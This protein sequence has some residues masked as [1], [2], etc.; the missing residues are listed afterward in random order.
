M[1]EAPHNS[2]DFTPL[3][4][5][6]TSELRDLSLGMQ[7]DPD[8]VPVS[9]QISL[10]EE[11]YHR[12]L[13]ESYQRGLADG[14]NLAERGLINVFRAL[15]TAAETVQALRE[16]ALRESEDELLH[17]IVM[18]ARKVIL[19]EVSQDRSILSEVV[20]NALSGLSE[21]DRITIRLN[22]D[23][24]ALAT[25]GRDDV[26]AIEAASDRMVL[27][28]DPSVISGGCMIDTEMGT[29]DATIDAQLDEIYRHL[30]EERSMTPSGDAD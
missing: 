28:A 3:G 8:H 27:K 1:T 5:F 18:V 6:D 23:D 10:A 2:D 16:K 13:D 30:L 15:R 29:L 11:E 21:R 24:Y 19:K 17:L 20:R 25:S 9:D 4:M 7:H 14:K 22:P 12:R 26:I